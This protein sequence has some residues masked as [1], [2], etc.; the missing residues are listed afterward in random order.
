MT[1]RHL[2]KYCRIDDDSQKLL[3]VAINKFGLSARAYE[4]ILKVARTI[5]DLASEEN[6]KSEHIPETIQSRIL[7]HEF[8][9]IENSGLVNEMK[10]F[11]L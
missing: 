5:T 6:I 11:S 10:L 7:D 3:E 1:T 2:K 8:E 4:R 9:L